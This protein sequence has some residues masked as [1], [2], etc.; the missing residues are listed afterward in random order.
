MYCL[1][2]VIDLAVL[3][4]LNSEPPPSHGHKIGAKCA[5][6]KHKDHLVCIEPPYEHPRHSPPH[7]LVVVQIFV[8]WSWFIR[9]SCFSSPTDLLL[10]DLKGVSIRHLQ[11]VRAALLAM[12]LSLKRREGRCLPNPHIVLNTGCDSLN[13]DY[14][15]G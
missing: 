12:D 8:Q 9:S 7:E 4:R 3:L 14:P 11:L 6:C 5:H 15:W 10:V 13:Q 2:L 1:H